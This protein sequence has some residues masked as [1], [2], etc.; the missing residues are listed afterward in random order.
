MR[1][2]CRLILLI[3]GVAP[4]LPAVSMLTCSSTQSGL[5]GSLGCYTAPFAVVETVDLQ[6]AFGVSSTTGYDPLTSGAWTYQTGMGLGIGLTLP[7]NYSG[8]TDTLLRADNFSSYFDPNVGIWRYYTTPGSPYQNYAAYQGMFDSVPD[9]G[10]GAPGDHLIGS[11]A[12]LGAMEIDFSRGISGI[13]FR[14]STPTSGDVN[15]VINAYAV[16]HPTALDVP[17]MTYRINATGA[18]GLCAGLS[19]G[20]SAPTPCNLAPWLGV[21]GGNG[22]IRSV[23]VSSSDYATYIG[24]FYLDD[25]F[26]GP[27]PG[28]FIL[29]GT[30]FAGLVLALKRRSVG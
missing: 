24:N 11:A 12:G 7:F 10:A 21:Q 15:A 25:A 19:N 18:A 26:S 29:F 6:T 23:I 20:F 16:A 27:E 1:R 22:Q 30:A 13:S 2:I 8:G 17:I 14:I 5:L 4:V 3:G 9:G 28:T